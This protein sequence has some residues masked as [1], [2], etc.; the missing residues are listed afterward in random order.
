MRIEVAICTWNRSALLAR[1]LQCLTEMRVPPPIEWHLLVINNNSTD[2]TSDVVRG[3]SEKLPLRAVFE[4]LPG[5]ANARNR[6]VRETTAEYLVWTDDDVLVDSEWL[7]AYTRAFARWPDAALFGGP[8]E[9]WFEGT[10]PRWLAEH[11]QKVESVFAVRQLGDNAFPFDD[12]HVPFGANY[13]IRTDV[14]QAFLYDSS[15]GRRPGSSVGGEET[16]LIRELLAAGHTGWWVPDARVRHFIPR[17]RQSLRYL[18][19]FFVGHGELNGRSLR[20]GQYRRVLGRPRLLVKMA[21]A[22]EARYRWSRFT[23]PP[24]V[25]ITRLTEAAFAWGRMKG[26]P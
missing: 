19:R 22:A 12:A 7:A 11:W 18:R 14:Q 10:P 2:A 9:P 16:Q 3:F 26:A 6:A 8:I 17:E 15:L 23:K 13:A 25:W 21:I 4:P 24:D 1:T 20:F 5:L